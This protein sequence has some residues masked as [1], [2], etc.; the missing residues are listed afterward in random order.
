MPRC[1]ELWVNRVMDRKDPKHRLMLAN[2]LSTL[3][4]KCLLQKTQCVKG[5]G[6]FLQSAIDLICD[7][8]KIWDYLG[9]II[10]KLYIQTFSVTRAMYNQY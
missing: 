6:K 9:E 5:L 7:I 2:L 4:K 8:P 3:V 1:V 10:G